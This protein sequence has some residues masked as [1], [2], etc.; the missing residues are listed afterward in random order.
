[1]TIQ[2]ICTEYNFDPFENSFPYFENFVINHIAKIIYRDE[3]FLS[4]RR[5]SN[6]FNW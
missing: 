6:L 1:M 5:G 2:W 3:I 4:Q